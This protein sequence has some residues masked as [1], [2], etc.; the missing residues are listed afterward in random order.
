MWERHP[1]KKS[2]CVFCQNSLPVHEAHDPSPVREG[3]CCGPCMME[4][5]L[6]KRKEAVADDTI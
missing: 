6:P 1:F 3:I 5:V 2:V 4:H